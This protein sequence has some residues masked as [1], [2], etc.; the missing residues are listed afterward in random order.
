[1]KKNYL[2]ILLVLT[3]IVY[4]QSFS[5]KY[6]NWDDNV[7]ISDNSEV[8]S[9]ISTNNIKSFFTKSYN[10]TY[11]PLTMVSWALEVEIFGNTPFWHLLINLLYHLGCV[12]F[13]YRIIQLLFKNNTAAILISSVFAL[14]PIHVESVSWITERKDVLYSFFFF[15]SIYFYI[16]DI[17]R[18]NKNRKYFLYS[19]LF[20][21]LSLLSKGQA[22]TLT[23]VIIG[24]DIYLN[25][26]KFNKSYIIEKIPFFLLS[27]IFGLIAIKFQGG[28]GSTGK[29]T[30][31]FSLANRFLISSMAL[32]K[33]IL[34]TI[35]P[36]QLSPINPLPS[37][38][39]A[40]P[41][42]FKIAIIFIPLYL[43]GL[44]YS[45]KK[46]IKLFLGLFIYFVC[47]VLMLD[48][49]RV[50]IVHYA[51]RFLYVSI[52]GFGIILFSIYELLSKKINIKYL[53]ISFGI[54]LGLLSI[55]TFFQT[56]IWHND[57][58]LFGYAIHLNEKNP[59]ALSNFA[60]VN[61]ENKDYK[62]AL[63]T[64]D[65]S[66]KLLPNFY[67]SLANKSLVL[68]SLK[69]YDEVIENSL[70]TISRYPKEIQSYTYLS[71]AYLA[72][73]NYSEAKI[74]LDKGLSID[75]KNFYV[76]KSLANFYYLTK[77]YQ[78]SINVINKILELNKE[79]EF[80]YYILAQN[81]IELG[82]VEKAFTY[83]EK[84][85]KINSD[86]SYNYVLRGEIYGRFKND[87][88]NAESDFKTAIKN[89]ELD[90]VAYN[91]YGLLKI[92]QNKQD[93]GEKLILKS[94]SIN[95]DYC[96]ALVN[97]TILKH[98]QKQLV[99]F[100]KY[101]ELSKQNNCEIPSIFLN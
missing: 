27:L 89:D 17:Q 51:D 40:L 34:S 26:L 74:Y 82:D 38:H 64:L 31:E 43:F 14:H 2:Y 4:F 93:E 66:L 28:Y 100:N 48:H 25:R 1:M 88:I 37:P 39:Y 5:G 77:E 10:S 6:L 94:L 30:Y 65:Q 55:K 70:K 29:I 79:K 101:F 68:M 67:N 20:F 16:K 90:Y 53:N 50:G 7:Y 58:S 60:M 81:Y 85:I 72:K 73:N 11:V 32:F 62:V 18:E 97:M 45:Y 87:F 46:N 57:A 91:N 99:D 69:K 47:I 19:I 21:I 41:S 86:V 8:L 3:A 9:G 61:F 12:Y 75:R 92:V 83:I 98:Q 78:N 35:F 15:I 33:Y 96:K 36:F 56:K 52:F 22:T 71:N 54:L 24:I 42:Y 13:V 23:L 80:L 59:V 63:E 95:K 76:Q 84:S 49:T 44:Y